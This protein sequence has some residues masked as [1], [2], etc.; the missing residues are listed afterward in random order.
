MHLEDKLITF[1]ADYFAMR[2]NGERKTMGKLQ[3][4]NYHQ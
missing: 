4:V 2:E 3:V 1:M